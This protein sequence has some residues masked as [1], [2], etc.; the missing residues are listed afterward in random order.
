[1]QYPEAVYTCST[2]SPMEKVWSDAI[3]LFAKRGY[4]IKIIDKSSGLL[5]SSP[6]SMMDHYTYENRKGELRDSSAYIVTS[7]QIIDPTEVSAELYVRIT[8]ENDHTFIQVKL[9][10]V[11][12]ICTIP[13]TSTTSAIVEINEALSTGILEKE[14]A[15]WLQ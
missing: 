9:L 5:N 11:R 8:S 1:M 4:S 6:I 14:I 10:N 7:R 12:S 13:G 2:N 15:K 3:D